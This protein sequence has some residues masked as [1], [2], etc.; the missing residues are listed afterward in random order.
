M[1]CYDHTWIFTTH[2]DIFIIIFH[3]SKGKFE[4]RNNSNMAESSTKSYMTSAGNSAKHYM[5]MLFLEDSFL[6]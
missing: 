6:V 5:V 3:Q 1:V 4:V 2:M